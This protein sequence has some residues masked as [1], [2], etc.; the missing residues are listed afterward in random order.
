MKALQ[1]TFGAKARWLWLRRNKAAF[2]D[3]SPPRKPRLLVDVSV[4]LRNDAGTGIQ[5]VVRSVWSQLNSLSSGEFDVVPVYAARSHGYCFAPL[6]FLSKLQRPGIVPVG[7]KKGDCFLGLDLAAHYL[8]KWAAQVEAWQANGAKVHVVV[9]DLLPWSRPDWFPAATSERFTPWLHSL[10]RH[11]DQLLCISEEVAGELRALLNRVSPDRKPKIGRLYL[12]GDLAASVPTFGLS[13]AVERTLELARK[14]PT[15][16]MVGTVEPR[17]AYDRAISAFDLLWGSSADAPS[18]LI[19][20]R[21]GW[22]TTA[23]QDRIRHHPEFGRRLYWLQEA[24]DEALNRAYI[25]ARAVLVT[26]HAEGFGLPLA[27]SAMHRRWALVRDLPVFREQ[28]FPNVH[29]FS[30]DSANAL[31]KSI[32]T[33]TSLAK[34]TL[35]PQANIP[36]WSWCVEQLIG[37]IGFGPLPWATVKLQMVAAS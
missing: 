15:L 4:I 1:E 10:I 16:L 36:S 8:P 26:S 2:V 37:E 3:H 12:S 28:Q 21:P 14:T 20:G 22:K 7:V 6:N 23:L 32:E 27:E 5:R 31:A 25:A 19:I 35:P 30:D 13:P 9:Y 34:Q 18:L 29:Y 11:A 33:I 24:S 17:K